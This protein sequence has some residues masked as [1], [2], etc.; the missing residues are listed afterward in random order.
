MTKKITYKKILKSEHN[1]DR[2]KLKAMRLFAKYDK[3]NLFSWDAIDDRLN[4]E[5][6]NT[7]ETHNY[8]CSHVSDKASY[9][10]LKKAIELEL[11]I[12]YKNFK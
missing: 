6:P 5:D 3:L 10:D 2:W 1:A 9:N 7:G 12:C 11:R 8:Y 4:C